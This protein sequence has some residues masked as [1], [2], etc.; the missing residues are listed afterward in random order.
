MPDRTANMPFRFCSCM[1]FRES[2]GKRAQD[3]HLLLLPPTANVEINALQ[4]AAAIVLYCK[5]PHA[6]GSGLQS[7][8]LCGKANR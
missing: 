8:K 4:Q 5:N 1:E 6:R 2:L 7:P 3:V